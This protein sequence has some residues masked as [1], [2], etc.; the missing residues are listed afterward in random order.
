MPKR[1]VFIIESVTFEDE[2]EKQLE[3]EFISQ[4]LHLGNI[5]SKYY[6]IR[7]EKELIEVLDLFE[8]SEYRYLHISSHGCKKSLD[9]ALDDIKFKRLGEILNPYLDYKRL[10]I[11]ACSTVN[12]AL[13]SQIFLN[14][15]CYS[16]IG[17]KKGIYF[18]DA[19]IFWASF[20]HLIMED[21][22]MKYDNLKEKINKLSKLFKVRMNYY[23]KSTGE[24]K[25]Y[26]LEKFNSK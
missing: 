14:K 21:D 16:I 26:K 1:G 3:G 19:A 13:A 18:G 10:F 23:R 12:E 11:S 24:K 25:G 9:L 8:K 6:F 4:I 15:K 22:K 7:T 17:P 5:P 2:E 20:Y